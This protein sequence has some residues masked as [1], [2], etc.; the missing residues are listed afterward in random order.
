[1]SS[2]IL[3]ASCSK[4]S[5]VAV[6]PSNIWMIPSDF[7]TVHVNTFL[8]PT[9]CIKL[10][11]FLKKKVP[12]SWQEAIRYIS[13]MFYRNKRSVWPTH[14]SVLLWLPF[15]TRPPC[16]R[17]RWPH[18]GVRLQ[19]AEVFSMNPGRE[20]R[21][22]AR[23]TARQQRRRGGHFLLPCLLLGPSSLRWLLR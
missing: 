17:P 2:Y 23:L 12:P 18:R 21:L 6:C 10:L 9:Y 16:F 7:M 19:L 5:T 20:E 15:L 11:F 22:S 14:T 13:S 4:L 3:G 1:M 8:T